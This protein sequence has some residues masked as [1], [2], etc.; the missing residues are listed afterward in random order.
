MIT[1]ACHEIE[2]S[3]TEA[4]TVTIRELRVPIEDYELAVTALRAWAASTGA[5]DARL[6]EK[7][8]ATPDFFP[9]AA[10]G[11]PDSPTEES[12]AMLGRMYETALKGER[13]N[14]ELQDRS[15]LAIPSGKDN[16]SGKDIAAAIAYGLGVMWLDAPLDEKLPSES[17]QIELQS[18]QN[19][20]AIH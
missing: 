14:A 3:Q 11:F 12:R 4:P 7:V 9:T 13:N 5:H 19:L 6:Q 2:P 10:I 8:L 1:I 16:Q 15:T 20:P 18:R 17:L